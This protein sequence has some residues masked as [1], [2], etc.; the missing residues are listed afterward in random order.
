MKRPAILCLLLSAAVLSAVR[1]PLARGAAGPLAPRVEYFLTADALGLF[2]GDYSVEFSSIL[3]PHSAW[4]VR[5]GYFKHRPGS[6][7]LYDNDERHWEV[8]FSW[9]LYLLQRS[10]NWLFVG[11]GWNNRPQDA[12]LTALGEAGFNLH[13]K[14]L[15]FG[16]VFSYGYE[17]YFKSGPDRQNRW[18]NGFE[19]RA[20]LSF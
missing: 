1:P 12:E 16:A 2:R 19:L 6:S 15:S 8:G 20:G 13:L 5:L 7:D 3:S 17:L 14:P 4:A 18:L 10:P 11:L 9:R